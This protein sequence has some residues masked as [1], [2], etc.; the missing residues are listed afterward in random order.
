LRNGGTK[1]GGVHSLCIDSQ[2][3]WLA[4]TRSDIARRI[5]IARQ[6]HVIGVASSAAP[7]AGYFPQGGTPCR[8]KAHL[9]AQPI[10]LQIDFDAVTLTGAYA[11]TRFFECE[12]LLVILCDDFFKLRA[13]NGKVV[14]GAGRP[15][16]SSTAT[17]PPGCNVNPSVSARGADAC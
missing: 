9:A 5:G 3:D 2:H 6:M 7:R 11:S 14:A 8:D 4:M 17:Q 16:K 13:C 15:S 1:T 10:Q 12:A